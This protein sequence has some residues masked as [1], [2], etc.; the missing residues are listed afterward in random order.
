[1]YTGVAELNRNDGMT[2]T[3]FNVHITEK[4]SLDHRKKVLSVALKQIFVDITAIKNEYTEDPLLKIKATQLI[5]D[6]L[7]NFCN[8]IR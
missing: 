8:K 6:S 7:Y 4:L 1:V 3:L 5:K 2:T